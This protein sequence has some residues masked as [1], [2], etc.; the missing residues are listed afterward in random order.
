M[1]GSF[2]IKLSSYFTLL[3]YASP[4][5]LDY[6]LLVVGTITAAA[7]GTPFPL[8]GILFGQLVDDLN[9]AS[10]RTADTADRSKIQ[11]R[12]NERVLVL[13]YIGIASFVLIYVYIVAWSVFSRR[14][15]AHLRDR[16]FSSML[17]QDAA[18]FDKRTAGEL[19]NRL[20]ADIQALQPGTSE[21][22]GICIACTSF[23][24]TGYIVAFIKDAKLAGMQVSLIPAFIRMA[25]AGKLLHAEILY[26]YVGLHCL[27]F[28]YSAGDS[29]AYCCC[30]GVWSWQ[31]AC[32]TSSSPLPSPTS[33][34]GKLLSYVSSRPQFS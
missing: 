34:P 26:A 22:V 15:E 21:K 30:A 10:W 12:I 17:R 16:Y 3:V 27:C 24:L 1:A 11:R 7:A 14:L 32:S 8:I 19:S 28:K 23:F 33:S 5:W 18:F 6:I 29:V 13:V 25:A 2:D 9:S 4:T 20:N 31:E